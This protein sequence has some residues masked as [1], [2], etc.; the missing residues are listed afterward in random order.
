[1]SHT[2]FIAAA[3]LSALVL[4]TWCAC[5]PILQANR[6]R[7]IIRDRNAPGEQHHAPEA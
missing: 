5:S 7:K 3:Y 6:L 4:L 1:M 2:P